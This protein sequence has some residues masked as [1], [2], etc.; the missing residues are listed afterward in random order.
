[1][2]WGEL[3]E[4]QREW[5]RGREGE[6]LSQEDEETTDPFPLCILFLGRKKQQMWQVRKTDKRKKMIWK[7]H[8][9]KK[10]SLNALRSSLFPSFLPSCTSLNLIL[11]PRQFPPRDLILSFPVSILFHSLALFSVFSV[12]SSASLPYSEIMPVPDKKSQSIACYLNAVMS[13]WP[14]LTHYK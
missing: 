1:M 8:E 13:V 7:E 14:F 12:P 2:L 5:G 11:N 3:G 6:F 10:S 4:G 9:R